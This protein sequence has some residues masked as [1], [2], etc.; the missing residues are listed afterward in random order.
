[1]KNLKLFAIA[2]LCFASLIFAQDSSATVAKRPA[3]LA[4]SNA[5]V[6]IEAGEIYPFGDLIDAVENTAYVG[7]GFRYTYWENV[8]GFVKFDYS[9]FEPIPKEVTYDGVHQFSGKL[10]LDF[11]WPYLKPIIFGAGFTC[12]W[13]RA[14]LDDAADKNALY[15]EPGGTLTDNET[16]FGWFARLNLPVLS[17]DNYRIGLNVLWE[18][19]WTLPERSDMLNVGVYVERRVW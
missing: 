8:D 18:E 10:G 6:S 16:E 1:M 13:T 17:T 3:D 2:I 11:K 4:F 12:N 19:L 7:L 15:S 5:F 14:D 9:Y